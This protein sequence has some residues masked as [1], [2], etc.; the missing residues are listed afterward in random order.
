MDAAT[1]SIELCKI[2]ITC[3]KS[4][5]KAGKNVETNFASQR[6]QLKTQIDD[7]TMIVAQVKN[8]LEVQPTKYSDGL[9]NVLQE[10]KQSCLRVKAFFDDLDRYASYKGALFILKSVQ[11]YFDIQNQFKDFNRV[12]PGQHKRLNNFILAGIYAKGGEKEEDINFERES[13]NEHTDL[14]SLIS[15]VGENDTNVETAVRRK[16]ALH[17]NSLSIRPDE[18]SKEVALCKG[19]YG[20]YSTACLDKEKVMI[21]RMWD[22]ADDNTKNDFTREKRNLM[23]FSDGSI[24]RV[25]GYCDEPNV[26][27]LVLEYM[28]QGKLSDVLHKS[29]KTLSLETKLKLAKTAAFALY[30]LHQKLVHTS[31]RTDMYLVDEHY[32]AKLSGLQYAK[33][34]TSARRF[35]AENHPV[36]D[37][38]RYIAPE[39][40]MPVK[41]TKA[42]DIYGF[43]IVL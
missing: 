7:I 13:K 19:S 18:I 21:L 41:P 40:F 10:L 29:G 37:V 42:A 39:R 38:N 31:L 36:V 6:G 35:V 17:R 8:T 28:E 24:V 32:T 34:F 27:F 1:S 22:D 26:K 20:N 11:H 23:F 16:D 2:I 14:Q 15:H 33:T 4:L 12:L 30:R 3:A 5:Y 9:E 43:G 25:I